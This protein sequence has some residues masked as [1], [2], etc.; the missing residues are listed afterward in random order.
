[1]KKKVTFEMKLLFAFIVCIL[2][3]CLTSCGVGS[4]QDGIYYADVNGTVFEITDFVSYSTNTYKLCLKNPYM[5]TT[6]DGKVVTTSKLYVSNINVI[7]YGDCT[8]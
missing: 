8:E 4:G 1:M 5:F 6:D 3:A 7:I 2:A